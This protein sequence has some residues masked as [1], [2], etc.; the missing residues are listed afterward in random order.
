VKVFAIQKSGGLTS[1]QNF[2]KAVYTSSVQCGTA[3]S[4]VATMRSNKTIV[5]NAVIKWHNRAA[6]NE[7][8]RYT[9]ARITRPDAGRF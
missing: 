2:V 3:S 8:E 5:T 6:E 7:S 4:E 9:L 1:S